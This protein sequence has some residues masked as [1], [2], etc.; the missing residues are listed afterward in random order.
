MA[1][2]DKFY[3]LELLQHISHSWMLNIQSEIQNKKNWNK[4]CDTVNFIIRVD[5]PLDLHY[6]PSAVATGRLLTEERK[7]ILKQEP[8]NGKNTSFPFKK[9]NPLKIYIWSS[10]ICCA[11]NK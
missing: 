1:V 9:K 5:M 2:T 10:F 7:S 11:T 4:L 3:F 6:S 8:V